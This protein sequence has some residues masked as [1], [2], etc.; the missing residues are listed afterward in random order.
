MECVT[1]QG[2][3]IRGSASTFFWAIVGNR[4]PSRRGARLLMALILQDYSEKGVDHPYHGK[5]AVSRGRGRVPS[6]VERA[7][8]AR[9]YDSKS[10]EHTA[11]M[12]A[13]QVSGR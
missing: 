2:C 5:H 11:L 12:L 3:T 13:H 9:Y 4:L 7:W 8:A 6:R 10:S 1:K